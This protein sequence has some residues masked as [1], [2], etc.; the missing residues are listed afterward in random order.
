[1]KVSFTSIWDDGTVVTTPGTY[2]PDTG[3]Y[4]LAGWH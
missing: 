2:D 4:R 3:E 1:M